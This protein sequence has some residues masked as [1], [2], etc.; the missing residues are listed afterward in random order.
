ML[1]SKLCHAVKQDRT[2]TLA[3]DQRR[4]KLAPAWKGMPVY[5]C[6]TTWLTDWD[7][8]DVDCACVR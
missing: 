6:R 5:S 7:E 1:E 4:M 3:Q 8:G 2:P